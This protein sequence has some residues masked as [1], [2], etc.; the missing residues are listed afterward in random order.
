MATLEKLI[1][2]GVAS[3]SL[4]VRKKWPVQFFSNKDGYG[5]PVTYG[6]SRGV[7]EWAI[8]FENLVDDVLQFPVT[9]SDGQVQS[10]FQYLRDFMDRHFEPEVKPFI[11]TCP[12][13]GKDYT[14]MFTDPTFE[15]SLDNFRLWSSGIVIAQFRSGEALLEG[16]QVD[17]VQSI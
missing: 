13:D 3:Y 1:T 5:Y 7:K 10:T 2:T 4:K 11:V 17:N 8:V 6:D 9:L 16:M 12:A 14:A 15:L